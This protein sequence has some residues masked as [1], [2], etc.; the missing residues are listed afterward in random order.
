M[1]SANDNVVDFVLPDTYY[2]VAAEKRSLDAIWFIKVK[3]SCEAIGK[4]N[5]DY[6]YQ[7]AAGLENIE[8]QLLGELGYI[9]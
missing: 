7:I 2:A 3:S 4:N 5:D 9:H 8:G 6:D 1:E